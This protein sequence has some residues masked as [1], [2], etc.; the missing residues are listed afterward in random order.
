[1]PQVDAYHRALAVC[2]LLPRGVYVSIQDALQD[3]QREDLFPAIQEIH[4]VV[5]VPGLLPSKAI[6]NKKSLRSLICSR[7]A[8][9]G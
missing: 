6:L 4:P 5:T 7:K 2:L 1:M 8:S 9:D 3:P